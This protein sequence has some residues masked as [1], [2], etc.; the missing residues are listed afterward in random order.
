MRRTEAAAGVYQVTWI[1]RIPRGSQMGSIRLGRTDKLSDKEDRSRTYKNTQY[2]TP[3]KFKS[4]RTR[5]SHG[6]Q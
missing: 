5:E 6:L 4:T 1:Y 3:I 2:T